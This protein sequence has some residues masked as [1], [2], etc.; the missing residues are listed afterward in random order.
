LSFKR[1]KGA[2]FSFSLMQT[3]NMYIHLKGVRLYAYHGVDPQETKVGAYFLIDLKL[4][5]D[6]RHASLTDELEGTVNYADIYQV[7]KEEMQTPSKLLEHA[8]QRI[9]QR[10]FNDFPTIE[11]LNIKLFKENPPMG[12]QTE[13]VGVEMCCK[14]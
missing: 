9:A 14:R 8:C 10:I 5:T 11:E 4:K 2:F 12:A 7:L 13:R 6:F 1:D 3:T